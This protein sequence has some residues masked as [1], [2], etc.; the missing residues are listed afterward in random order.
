MTTALTLAAIRGYRISTGE[1]HNDS[2]SIVLYGAYQPRGGI[3]RAARRR[4]PGLPGGIPRT[5]AR[6]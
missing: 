1:L 3:P 4:R 5:T 6:T 2:T